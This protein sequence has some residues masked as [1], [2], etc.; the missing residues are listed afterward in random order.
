M[1]H[2]DEYYDHDEQWIYVDLANN[3][4]KHGIE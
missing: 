2:D 4:V 3:L 1:E